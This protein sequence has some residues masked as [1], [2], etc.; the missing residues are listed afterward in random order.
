MKSLDN[1]YRL[2]AAISNLVSIGVLADLKDFENEE[3]AIN[4]KLIDFKL[5]IL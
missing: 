1:H 5:E 4:A 2:I 3:E